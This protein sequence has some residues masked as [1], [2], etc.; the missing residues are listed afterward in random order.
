[1][2]RVSFNSCAGPH[3]DN[4]FVTMMGTGNVKGALK[5]SAFAS[6]PLLLPRDTHGLSTPL[7]QFPCC[8]AGEFKQGVS[9]TRQRAHHRKVACF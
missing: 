8:W 6:A 9:K 2:L 5:F 7:P 1:M 4:A 3:F